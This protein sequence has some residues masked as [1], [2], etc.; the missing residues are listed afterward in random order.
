MVGRK[1]GKVQLQFC[2]Y[3]NSLFSKILRYNTACASVMHFHHKI[4]VIENYLEESNKKIKACFLLTR[5]VQ[6]YLLYVR[7]FF[8]TPLWRKISQCDCACCFTFRTPQIG[9]TGRLS[10]KVKG[11]FLST[12]LLSFAYIYFCAS[13]YVYR[14]KYSQICKLIGIAFYNFSK[15]R[16]NF[17]L[18]SLN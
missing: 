7:S 13:K 5:S 18:N 8:A 15:L 17:L 11:W 10:N 12:Y 16:V 9:V 4:F 6:N 2:Q 1:C 14:F 3:S